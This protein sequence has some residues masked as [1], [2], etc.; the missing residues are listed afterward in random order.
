MSVCSV[1]PSPATRSLLAQPSR[2]HPQS[3][4]TGNPLGLA[5]SFPLLLSFCN[6][7]RQ[8]VHSGYSSGQDRA[9]C[10]WDFE[11]RSRHQTKKCQ[12]KKKKKEVLR[13]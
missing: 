9:L 5:S 1:L 8:H 2:L 3:R 7:S 12:K 6:A 10:S 4:L 11:N 13:N